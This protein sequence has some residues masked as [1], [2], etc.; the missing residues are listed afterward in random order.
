MSFT[1]QPNTRLPSLPTVAIEILKAFDDP[2]ADAQRIGDIVQADPAIS[3]K[4]LQAANSPKYSR[5]GEV[6]DVRRAVTMMGKNN[7]TPLVLSFSLCAESMESP[8]HAEHFRQFWLRSFVQG[9]AAEILGE[10]R[11]S[12]FASECFTINLL[13][14]IGQLAMLKLAPQQFSECRQRLRSE[15][16]SLT[17]L[18]TEVFGISHLDLS[19]RMLE[20][21]GLP[22]R[23]LNAVRFLASP[24]VAVRS[25]TNDDEKTLMLVTRCAHAVTRYLCDASTGLAFVALEEC[26]A[27]INEIFPVDKES[28][29]VQVRERLDVCADLFS[30][31]PSRLPDPADLLQDAL[32]QL[33]TFATMIHDTGNERRVPAE[34]LEENGRLKLRVEDLIRETSIDPLTRVYNRAFFSQK[35]QELQAV[36]RLRKQDFGV[37]VM[38]IDHFK[39]VNDTHGH[40]AGDYVLKEVAQALCGASRANE[41]LA[42]YG[43]EEFALLLENTTPAGTA[44]VAERMRT[45]VEMLDLSF[46]GKSIPVTISVGVASGT[47]VVDDGF[48]DQL[49]ALA[50]AALYQAKRQG[51]NCAVIDSSLARGS[52]PE[53]PDAVRSAAE[54][55]S[56]AV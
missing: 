19:Q 45:V 22:E 11:G 53:S 16:K 18:E 38:D 43:G 31:D 26:V 32:E 34:L 14:G 28:L 24:V 40:A 48:A 10:S 2:D 44:I 6:S 39:Q 23:C 37:A 41:V 35:L 4:V 52:V 29:L 47:P 55:E 21:V 9:V 12:R 30:I 50:D 20:K 3:S 25:N 1:I 46:A 51:R 54:L 33:S 5:R 15:R 56:V 13:A 17:E 36:S 27:E 49:F 7:V 8:E 42:R